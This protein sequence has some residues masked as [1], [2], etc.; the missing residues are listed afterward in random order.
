MLCNEEQ[1]HQLMVKR[2]SILSHVRL[3]EV[4]E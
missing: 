4:D 3:V 2:M 1:I